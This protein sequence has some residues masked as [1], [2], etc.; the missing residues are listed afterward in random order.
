MSAS[1]S[2]LPHAQAPY[3]VFTD[4][5]GTITTEDSNDA[6]TDNLGCGL[7]KRR[8]INLEILN[9]TK[10]FRDAF[11]EMIDSVAANKTFDETRE[12]LRSRI[13]LDAGFKSFFEWCKAHDVPVVIVSSGMVPI[14]RA[15]MENLVGK[16]DAAKIDII[17][18]DVEYL[19][20]GK[21][22][23]KFRHP[24]SGFGHDKSRS[25]SPYRDLEH[26]PTLFFCGDGV[27]DLSAARAADLLF[28]KVV[29]GHTNDLSVHCDREKIPYVAFE[30]FLQVKDAVADVIEK[31]ATIEQLLKQ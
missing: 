2:L 18:N 5:D 12:Y 6:A 1:S 10:D 9:G 7:E 28:V 11:R 31:R 16:E 21:W 17:A 24:E 26:K 8:A 4:F 3:I 27:S 13:K 25:T 30:Q 22:T 19:P 23:I 15:I 14:I 29:P 20:D